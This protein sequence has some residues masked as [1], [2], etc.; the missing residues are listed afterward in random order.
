MRT[1]RTGE[2]VIIGTDDV[3]PQ[4]ALGLAVARALDSFILTMIVAKNILVHRG[5]HG[6]QRIQNGRMVDFSEPAVQIPS[7]LP[8]CRR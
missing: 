4:T 8:E 3:R 1:I 5:H 2:Q 7:Q 6:L